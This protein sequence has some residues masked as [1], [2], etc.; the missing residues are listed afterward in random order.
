MKLKWIPGH[1]GIQGN[2]IFYKE[3][4]KA[5]SGPVN[6]SFLTDKDAVAHIKR[7]FNNT[8]MQH[9]SRDLTLAR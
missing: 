7:E 4:K 5:A 6:N 9:L 8:A 2:E 1:S 3:A